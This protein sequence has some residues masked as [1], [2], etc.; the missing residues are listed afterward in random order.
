[1]KAAIIILSDP[2][3]GADEA[4]SRM[5][6]GLAMADEC[7]R[8]G[9]QLE[10]LFAGSGTRWPAELNRLDDPGNPIFTRL[11]GNVVGASR[12]CAARNE[13]LDGLKEASIPLLS[14]NAVEGT[15]GVAS[16]RRYHEEGWTVT[17]F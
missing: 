13:A 9:D 15:P 10:I 5:L 14:D 8:A 12:S 4:R 3:S 2:K 16:I 7:L 17:Q 11:R 1:M 6:N